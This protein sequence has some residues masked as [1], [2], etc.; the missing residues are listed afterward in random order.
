M[1][2]GCWDA[3]FHYGGQEFPPDCPLNLQVPGWGS[4]HGY[5]LMSPNFLE[6]GGGR[7]HGDCGSEQK[8][9][10]WWDPGQEEHE[11]WGPQGLFMGWEAR[12]K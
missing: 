10:G 8:V 11:T 4:A 6:W 9:G 5:S 2:R 7:D 1:S 12:K 3:H